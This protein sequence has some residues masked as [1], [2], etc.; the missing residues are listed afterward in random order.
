[1]KT[2]LSD[3]VATMQQQEYFDPDAGAILPVIYEQHFRKR[4]GAEVRVLATR[5]AYLRV[6]LQK[7]IEHG[8]P[9]CI[10]WARFKDLRFAIDQKPFAPKVGDKITLLPRIGHSEPIEVQVIDFF[11]KDT[12]GWN[13]KDALVKLKV[14]AAIKNHPTCR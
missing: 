12:E 11:F 14:R 3:F 2:S 9:Q 10:L 5:Y 8:E 13:P 7:N 1:M 4:E 6:F